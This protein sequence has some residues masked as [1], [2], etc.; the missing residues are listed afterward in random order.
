MTKIQAAVQ[1]TP[2]QAQAAAVS[3]ETA[4][5]AP[6]QKQTPSAL[7][8]KDQYQTYTVKK[9]DTLWDIAGDKLGSPTKWPEIFGMNK[10]QIKNPDLIYPKQVLTLPIIKET[11]AQPAQPVAPTQPVAPAEPPAPVAPPVAVAPP[12]PVAPPAQP[13]PPQPPTPPAVVPTPQTPAE[14]T[15]KHSILNG[16]VRAAAIGGAI[17][18]VG[19]AAAL[20]VKTATLAHPIANFGGYATAQTVAKSINSLTSKVGF[21]VPSGPALSKAISKMGGPKVAGAGL[22]IGVGIAAAGL[23]VGGYYLYQKMDDK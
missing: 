7:D 17:G 12:A 14:P 4:Q 2:P 20:V 10:E 8:N 16:V 18:T 1:T 6:T 19:T 9:G 23:A 11:P 15:P 5:A 13:E 22:A 21:T 3:T